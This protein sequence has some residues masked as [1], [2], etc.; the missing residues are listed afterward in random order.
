MTLFTRKRKEKNQSRNKVR[1]DR[2]MRNRGEIR[3]LLWLELK[4]AD[5]VAEKTES[6]N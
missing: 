3:L 2:D 6:R 4:S 1:S 5:R